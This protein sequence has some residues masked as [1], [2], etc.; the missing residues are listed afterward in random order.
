MVQKLANDLSD[1]FWSL[2]DMGE[3]QSHLK[4]YSKSNSTGDLK[5]GSKSNSRNNAKSNLRVK[6]RGNMS[7]FH[8]EKSQKKRDGNCVDRHKQGED[9]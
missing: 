7:S 8:Y 4:I 9:R 2:Y 3:L 5:R 1:Y 6:S